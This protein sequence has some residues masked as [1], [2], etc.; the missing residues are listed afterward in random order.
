M[1]LC[2]G[3]VRAGIFPWSKKAV[4]ILLITFF[5][6]IVHPFAI[7]VTFGL[8]IAVTGAVAVVIVILTTELHVVLYLMD[9]RAWAVLCCGARNRLDDCC[10][11]SIFVDLFWG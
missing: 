6:G 2:V 9:N 10:M 4:T 5:V 1:L 8:G 7:V 11:P 3:H